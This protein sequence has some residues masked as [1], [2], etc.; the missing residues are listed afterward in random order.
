MAEVV[1]VYERLYTE[2]IG[3]LR[4]WAH[5]Y[6]WACELS[7][8]VDVDDLMQSGFLGLVKA[9]Q[10]FQEGRAAWSTWASYYIRGAMKKALC[11]H[12]KA[13]MRAVSLDAPIDAPGESL[14][15]L[16]ED[17]NMPPVDAKVISDETVIAVR[18]A[19]NAL[20][21]AERCAV[22]SIR[23]EG[24]SYAEAAREAGCT[25]NQI[26]NKLRQGESNLRKNRELRAIALDIDERTRFCAHKGV[27]AFM[28]DRTS[29]VEA[30]VI[31]RE[32]QRMR[33]GWPLN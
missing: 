31:W 29:T 30:A 20:E 4:M 15:N 6:A 12:D 13:Q 33:R 17:R 7:R 27:T 18:S 9:A 14:G 1:N 10:T 11:V 28:R 32:A 3:L 16:L 24:K 23:L 19:V 5:R 21:A 22:Q 25:R 8:C 2:N 26:S